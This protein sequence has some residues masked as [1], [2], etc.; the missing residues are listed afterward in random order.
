M[1]YIGHSW[2]NQNDGILFFVQRLQEML[3]HYSDDIV[4]APVHNSATLIM[5]YL[6][7]DKDV[8]VQKYHL[9][10]IAEELKDSLERDSIAKSCLGTDNI[11][12]II[13]EMKNDQGNLIKYLYSSLPFEVYHKKTCLYLLE[14][15][16]NPNQKEEIEY[17][18]RT[19]IAS[20]VYGGYRSEYIYRHLNK[21]FAEVVGN[22]YEVAENF[23]NHFDFEKKEYAVYLNFYKSV[24]PYKDLLSQRL[25]VIFEDD[26]NFEKIGN[27]KYKNESFVGKIIVK[28]LDP[29]EAISEAYQ[30]L[31]IFFSFYRVISNRGTQLLGKNGLV[32][33]DAEEMKL[34]VVT[35]GYKAIELE[36]RINL[37]STID[38]MVIG[39]QK[40]DIHTYYHL[41]KMIRLYNMALIQ[42][43]LSDGFVN[44]WSILE[45][46]SSDASL[47]SKIKNVV[48]SILPIL[49]N[50]Y[51]YKIFS[52]ILD[53][54][55]NNLS[56]A[57]MRMLFEK[58]KEGKDD[59]LHKIIAFIVLPQYE[60]LRE[61]FF[62]K[63]R[64]FPNIRQK[65]YK[66]YITK[67]NKNKMIKI[68]D[69]YAQRIEWHLYRLYR[70]RNAIVHAGDT[71]RNIRV[72]GEHL[73]IY[74]DSV[75]IE[76]ITKLASNDNLSTVKDVLIDTKLLLGKKKEYLKEG[77]AFVDEDISHLRKEYL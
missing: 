37:E 3:F 30:R 57:D 23:I 20:V 39:C 28:E 13:S 32:I 43:D 60:K 75:I 44:L 64:D 63:L 77:G 10:Y 71:D 14:K 24:K 65:I 50:D 34:P 55:S 69:T 41:Q 9:D 72:L 56:K 61:E 17:A 45:V 54:L 52:S 11:N 21:L 35:N 38:N 26:G 25:E 66:I 6:I 51:Y 31:D 74:C 70:V 42:P 4:K 7:T 36:P 12:R 22:P 59:R 1:K 46:A 40:K 8:S 73:H 16:N 5:E 15:I 47:D 62:E 2:G 67:D 53:D 19:W 68:S 48:H 76:L 49:Q 33:C 27:T 18:L 29:Y 58:V